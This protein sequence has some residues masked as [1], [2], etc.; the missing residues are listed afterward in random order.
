MS[1]N[2]ADQVEGCTGNLGD[3]R[4]QRV[5]NQKDQLSRQ[6]RKGGGHGRRR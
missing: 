5:A 6:R 2:L 1:T 3:I 4:K